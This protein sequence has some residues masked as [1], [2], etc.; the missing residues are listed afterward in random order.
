[1]TKF[2]P[3]LS[4]GAIAQFPVRRSVRRRSI[5]NLMLDGSLLKKFDEN[6]NTT[7][8]DL[9]YT[10]LTDTERTNVETLY[11]DCEGRL[12]GFMFLDP[13]DNLLRWS[14]DLSQSVWQKDPLL[15][16]T[17]GIADPFGGTRASR[18]EN[19]ASVPQTLSQGLPVPSGLIY[20]FSLMIRSEPASQVRLIAAAG[21]TSESVVCSAVSSWRLLSIPASLAAGAE[22]ITFSVEVPGTHS[23]EIYGL[24]VEAQPNP[25]QYKKT[26]LW[27]GVYQA[28]FF[29]DDRLQV[30]TT[31]PNEHALDIKLTSR[32]ETS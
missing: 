26:T 5:R 29:S 8:W 19:R 25:S 23:I 9:K 22:S 17:G 14:E 16:A 7:H 4:T 10:G 28:T 20:S 32:R 30:T 13:T 1:M 27:G 21:S 2:F 18:L 3:Q 11:R 12:Q 6:A 24:Q 31:G 15:V